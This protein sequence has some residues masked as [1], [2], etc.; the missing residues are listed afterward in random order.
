LSEEVTLTVA[1]GT[2]VAEDLEEPEGD[3]PRFFD[4]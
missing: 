4:I 1:I 3:N 2:G